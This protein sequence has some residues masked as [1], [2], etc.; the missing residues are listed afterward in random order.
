MIWYKLRRAYDRLADTP[1]DRRLWAVLV[2]SIG[3]LVV[4]GPAVIYLLELSN[5]PGD[6]EATQ[7]G[8]DGE[9]IGG[10]KQTTMDLEDC[11]KD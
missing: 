7:L 11:W 10:D 5:Y 9:Y 6:L 3:L 8:F 2:A 4:S 1:S